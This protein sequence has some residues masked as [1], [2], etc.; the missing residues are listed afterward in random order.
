MDIFDLYDTRSLCSQFKGYMRAD[1]E[2]LSIPYPHPD[3]YVTMFRYQ[4]TLV[5]FAEVITAIGKH[6][7]III[8]ILKVL[9]PFIA[10]TMD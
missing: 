4:R 2:A 8:M 3:D 5:L 6:L 1:H 9:Y 7:Y 10:I